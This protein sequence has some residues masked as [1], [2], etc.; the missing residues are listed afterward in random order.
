MTTTAGRRAATVAM[1]LALAVSISGVGDGCARRPEPATSPATT[2]TTGAGKTPA[3]AAVPATTLSLAVASDL[4]TVFPELEA[5]FRRE[6]P[7]VALRPTFGASGRLAEQIK[8]GAPFDLYIAANETFVKDLAA[9]QYIDTETIR[10]YA[11]GTLVLAVHPDSGGAVKA[12]ADVAGGGVRRLAIANPET[13]P[14]GLAAKQALERSGLWGRVES[15]VVRAE[16]VRQAL[17]FV[18]TGNAEAGLVGHAAAG[19]SA[20][21]VVAV[22]PGLYDPV[23]QSLGV[24]SA[25]G[26]PA[27]ARAFAR[28]LCQGGGRDVLRSRGFKVPPAPRAG[29]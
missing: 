9:G 20:V 22:D 15:K 13:A 23:V 10:P 14:Y 16:S 19:D 12:L 3:T 5:G 21:R 24:V 29:P 28:Y 4:Q 2:A 8:A 17:Q 6:A 27:E 26:R 25:A 18:E 7:A 1:I 11:V